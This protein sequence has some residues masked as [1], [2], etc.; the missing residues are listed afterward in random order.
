MISE[1]AAWTPKSFALGELIPLTGSLR[2]R[3]RVN[4]SGSGDAVV[5][6]GL[7]EVRL[8]GDRIVCDAWTPPALALPPPV[9]NTLASA[10]SATT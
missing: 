5:E 8:E 3:V 6:G 7:D 10:A 1:E 9:G 4:D 2:V